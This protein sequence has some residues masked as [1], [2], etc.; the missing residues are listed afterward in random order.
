[1]RWLVQLVSKAIHMSSSY[2]L[3]VPHEILLIFAASTVDLSNSSHEVIVHGL[4][5]GKFR[6]GDCGEDILIYPGSFQD[7]EWNFLQV[8]WSKDFFHPT[9]LGD[10]ALIGNVIIL[11]LTDPS[12]GI[13]PVKVRSSSTI[14]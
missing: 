5:S 3:R 6:Y 13:P 10:L 7:L 4:R 1:M 12:H 8:S 9:F 14:C 2:V 11:S